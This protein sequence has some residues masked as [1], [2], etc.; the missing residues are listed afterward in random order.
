MP[1]R[2]TA[3]NN[4]HGRWSSRRAAA[5]WSA[6]TQGVI[7][8]AGGFTYNLR[9]LNKHLPLYGRHYRSIIRMGSLGCDG[10]GIALGQT[11][12]GATDHMGSLFSGRVLAPPKPL[13]N[14]NPRQSGRRAVYQRGNL[15]GLSGKAIGEQSEGQAWLIID[16]ATYR[17]TIL[18]A[19]GAGWTSFRLF[20]LPSLLNIFLG[21]TKKART[22]EA[23]A[24]RA[25][26]PADNL[27]QTVAAHN[28][29]IASGAPD[30]TGKK[31]RRATGK[32]PYRAIDMS[33]RGKFGFTMMFTLGGLRVNEETGNVVREDGSIIAGL[34]A[35][36][37]APPWACARSAILAGYPCRTAFFRVAVLGAR[38]LQGRNIQ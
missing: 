27:R 26:I 21:R 37:P 18:E 35:G 3:P 11:A 30:P 12:G 17:R 13:L 25:G 32:G 14:G 2:L 31:T 5:N 7:L 23:L 22:L 34:F 28:E 38:R 15:H 33:I 9:L 1:R 8:A 24:R 10:S 16:R 19:L 6:R 20:A 4:G 36:R 29:A